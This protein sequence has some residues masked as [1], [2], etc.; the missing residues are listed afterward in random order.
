MANRFKFT[1]EHVSAG[2]KLLTGKPL[3]HSSAKISSTFITLALKL[4]IAKIIVMLSTILAGKYLGANNF[5]SLALI[6]AIGNFFCLP[7]FTSWGLSYVNLVANSKNHQKT[8]ELLSSCLLLSIISIIFW[9]PLLIIFKK[10]FTNALHVDMS[11]W[12]WGCTFGVLMGGYYF[13]KN[14]FQAT[15]DWKSFATCELLFA[16]SM[17]IGILILFLIQPNHKFNSVISV[18]ILAHLVG[19]LPAS[20]KIFYKLRVPKLTTIFRTFYYG[21]GL[22]VSF[23]LSL[24]AMQLDKLFLNHFVDSTAVGRYQ[25]YYVSTFGILNG[26]TTILNNYLLP[27]YGKYNKNTLKNTLFRFLLVTS[28]PLCLCCLIFGRLAFLIFGKDFSFNWSE[29]AWASAFNMVMFYLQVVV[30]FSMS[31][32]IKAIACNTFVYIVFILIQLIYMPFLIQTSGVSGAF[33]G[34]ALACTVSLFMLLVLLFF[35]INKKDRV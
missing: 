13:L 29:L 7:F 30:F 33:Q 34:M 23:G 11:V 2:Y 25:A 24:I 32:G 31:Y 16:F 15:Q 21:L 26:F 22:N 9:T 12:F 8:K 18:F 27:L 4:I 3:T 1:L 5:G 35:F 20:V 19:S 10:Q 28:L 17:M 6:L 14:T